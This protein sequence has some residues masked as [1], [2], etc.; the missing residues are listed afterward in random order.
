MTYDPNTTPPPPPP[1][2]PEEPRVDSRRNGNLGWIL[3]ALIVALVVVGLF[4]VWPNRETG[5]ATRDIPPTTGVTPPAPQT[6]PTAPV[7]PAEPVQ[8]A[9]P[10]QLAPAPQP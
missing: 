2:R 5:V 10:A 9:P 1:R 4:F 3:G 8:P 7:T 6:A